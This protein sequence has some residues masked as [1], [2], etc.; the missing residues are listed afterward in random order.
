MNVYSKK[1]W[2]D[3]NNFKLFR[4]YSRGHVKCNDTACIGIIF[5]ASWSFFK[6]ALIANKVHL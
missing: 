5:K 2:G 3:L 6:V 1:M 4:N